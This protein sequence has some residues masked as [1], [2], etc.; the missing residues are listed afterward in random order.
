MKKTVIGFV[1][2][3][4]I[5]NKRYIA[6]IDTGATK[7]SIDERLAKLLGLTDLIDIKEVR[8]A[9]GEVLRPVVR[10]TVMIEG[11]KITAPFTLA[12]R[13]NLRHKVLIGRNILKRGFIID[14]SHESSNH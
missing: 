1:A 6:R 7:S 8:N 12:N 3:V 14:P 4:M 2:P 9:H 5:K 11:R 13:K 10:I